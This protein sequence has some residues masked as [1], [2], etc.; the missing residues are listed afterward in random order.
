MTIINSSD[1]DSSNRFGIV[2]TV[3]KYVFSIWCPSRVKY[4]ANRRQLNIDFDAAHFINVPRRRDAD[5][6][7]NYWCRWGPNPPIYSDR[8][9]WIRRRWPRFRWSPASPT[10]DTPTGARCSRVAGYNRRGVRWFSAIDI[11]IM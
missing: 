1:R 3:W 7:R 5:S 6:G 2:K 9:S 10:P 4:S 11:N 8:T